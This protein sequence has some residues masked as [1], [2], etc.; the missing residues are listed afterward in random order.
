MERL[1][2]G[3][4][5]LMALFLGVGYAAS[6]YHFFNGTAAQYAAQ[7]DVPTIRSLALLMLVIGIALGFAN[8][9]AGDSPAD[10]EPAN[11]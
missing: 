10:E 11:S 9:P 8:S 5:L 6:Q 3:Y 1:R 2:Y 4:V 7:V